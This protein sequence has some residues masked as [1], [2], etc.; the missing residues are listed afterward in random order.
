MSLSGI[1]PLNDFIFDTG[2]MLEGLSNQ[3]SDILFRNR[4]S[5]SYKKSEIVFK[6][7]NYASGIYLVESGLIKKFKVDS[8]GIEQIFYLYGKGE[9]FGYHALLNNR[10]HID[11]TAAICDSNLFFIPRTD[12]HELLQ[13][14]PSFGRKLLAVLSNEFDVLSNIFTLYNQR[15]LRE[16]LILILIN[17]REKFKAPDFK[18]GDSVKIYVSRID[19]ASMLGTARESVVRILRDLKAEGFIHTKGGMIEI[20]DVKKLLNTVVF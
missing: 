4:V 9:I 2:K 12:F 6:D 19:I 16:R 10:N 11:S 3:E 14:S 7:G 15:S 20:T 17:L 18:D 8:V 5:Q 1:F 13:F